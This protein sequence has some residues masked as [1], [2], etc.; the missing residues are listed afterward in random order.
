MCKIKI[1][2]SAYHSACF[3]TTAGHRW[4]C[5][6]SLAQLAEVLHVL[7]PLGQDFHHCH[8]RHCAS[9][10]LHQPVCDYVS[11][12]SLMPDLDHRQPRQVSEEWL[13]GQIPLP[14]MV[15]LELKSF[16]LLRCSLHFQ[17]LRYF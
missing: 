13:A 12:S 6:S 1:H 14:G 8:W 7:L 5:C 15:V 10:Q 9:L 4:H 16:L 11:L 3:W 17:S 2:L